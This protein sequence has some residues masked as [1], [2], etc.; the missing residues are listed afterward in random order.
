VDPKGIRTARDLPLTASNKTGG[1][2]MN[3]ILRLLKDVDADQL[4]RH[5]GLE[6]RH[7]VQ[8]ASLSLLSIG[9]A[10]VAGLGVG[11]LL[12]PRSGADLRAQLKERWDDKTLPVHNAK[13]ERS[14]RVSPT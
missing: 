14:E 10:A 11:L 7:P 4:L 8:R 6:R 3:N 9:A 1:F 5:L 13:R 12:A 2:T